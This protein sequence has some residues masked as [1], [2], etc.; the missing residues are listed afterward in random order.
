M[1][2]GIY[3]PWEAL[4]I[5][6]IILVAMWAQSRAYG[7]QYTDLREKVIVLETNQENMKETSKRQYE[8]IVNSLKEV[9]KKLDA[10][11][12]DVHRNKREGD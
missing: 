12:D 2:E 9:F 5:L 3:L 4:S 7:K 11:G 8:E 6:V 10:I 1:E